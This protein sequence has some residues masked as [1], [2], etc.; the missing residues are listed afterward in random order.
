[1]FA[2]ILLLIANC[3]HRPRRHEGIAGANAADDEG[4]GVP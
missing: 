4:R 1:M 2:D 3:G